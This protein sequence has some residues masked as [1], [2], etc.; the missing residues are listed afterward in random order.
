M[1]ETNMVLITPELAHQWLLDNNF[2]NRN[3]RPSWVQTLAQA[4][5]NNEFLTTHQAIAFSESGRLLDGQHRLHAIVLANK[6]VK[7]LVTTNLNENT[8]SAIDCGIKRTISD[9]TKLEKG[10]AEIC[11]LFARLIFR[12]TGSGGT[13]AQTL[14]IAE[15]GIAE[16]SNE[17]IKYCNISKKIVSST[18][19]RSAAIIHILN[20]KPK[21]LIFDYYSN[22][23]K[24]NFEQLAPIQLSFLKQI[25]ETNVSAGDVNYYVCRGIK[26]FDPKNS[27]ITSL[28]IKESEVNDLMTFARMTL[29]NYLGEPK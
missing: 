12:N 10:T 22:L 1:I 17:L 14:K 21:Q 7:M 20:G 11:R 19:I 24:Y 16:L 23:V 29:K 15:S 13:A 26:I 5:K 3:L 25:S 8:F 4:I 27:A 6:P 28:R 18:S 9:L 2:N